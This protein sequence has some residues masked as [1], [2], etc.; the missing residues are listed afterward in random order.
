LIRKRA[1]QQSDPML[2]AGW[3]RRVFDHPVTDP[4]W[5]WDV[6][7]DTT[8]PAPPECVAHLTR[9]FEEPTVLA[10]YS[11]AQVNQGFW[12]LLCSSCSNYMF[13][14]TESD[15][16]WSLRQRGIRAIAILF[17]R[18]FARRCSNH[19]S[20]FDEQGAGPLNSAC[21]MWWDLF[22]VVGPPG[23]PN[24]AELDAELFAVMKQILAVDSLACQ[25]SAL[26]GLGHWHVYYPEIVHQAIDEFLARAGNMRQELRDY[27]VCARRGY[28]L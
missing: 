1:L 26:H 19:L 27:A 4:A 23:N 2:F 3:L 20:H 24:Y 16:A 13:S 5:H 28:V 25:E 8:E 14:L 22:P 7:A 12:Y 6:G 21:Y 15:V 10:A 18:L 9:L 11:D 17:E